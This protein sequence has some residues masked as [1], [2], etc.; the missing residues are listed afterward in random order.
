ML[1]NETLFQLNKIQLKSNSQNTWIKYECYFNKIENS[2]MSKI[3]APGT[4]DIISNFSDDCLVSSK[5]T[6]RPTITHLPIRW[7]YFPATQLCTPRVHHNG[8]NTSGMNKTSVCWGKYCLNTC[9]LNLDQ[10]ESWFSLFQS[11]NKSGFCNFL[12]GIL[13]IFIY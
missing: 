5:H 8:C 6:G 12:S 7:S 10:K 9:I 4:S 11:P 2:I 1:T 3:C 13:K